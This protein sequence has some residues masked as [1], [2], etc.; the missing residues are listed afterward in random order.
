MN[1][2]IIKSLKHLKLLAQVKTL[3]Y[4]TTDWHSIPKLIFYCLNTEE[5][6]DQLPEEAFFA[7]FEWQCN[8]EG[9]ITLPNFDPIQRKKP[10]CGQ[11]IGLSG[12]SYVWFGNGEALCSVGDTATTFVVHNIAADRPMISESWNPNTNLGP[13]FFCTMSAHLLLAGISGQQDWSYKAGD[14]GPRAGGLKNL[15]DVFNFWSAETYP[16]VMNRFATRGKARIAEKEIREI[17]YKG[18]AKE[19]A[20][21]LPE[22]MAY[23][24]EDVD[25]LVKLF[26]SMYACWLNQLPM[27]ESQY[28][29]FKRAKVNYS[30]DS[31]FKTWFENTEQ[32]Y[33]EALQQIDSKVVDLT[34]SIVTNFT[35]EID[36]VISSNPIEP[37]QECYT[38]GSKYTKLKAK[39]KNA[40]VLHKEYNPKLNFVVEKYADE[41]P[42]ISW[43][44]TNNGLP[45]WADKPITSRSVD[46][47][48]L[49]KPKYRDSVESLVQVKYARECGFYYEKSGLRVKITSPKKGLNTKDNCGS[50]FSKDFIAYWENDTLST[51]APESKEIVQ[52]MG[53]ISYWTSVRSRLAEVYASVI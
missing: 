21:R 48:L 13:N 37:Q 12:K 3:P 29:Y 5:I 22:L 42:C 30:L 28:F 51:E 31:D 23:G 14:L 7:D 35:N 34:Q 9:S 40:Y 1:P 52:L 39:Y 24:L 2:S 26:P 36:E 46:M 38:K 33:Q 53:S 18:T 15:I 20:A 49:L 41:Y 32:K 25:K 44:L 4:E 10:F 11:F 16:E 45:L 17:F 6:T 27:L 50:L 8:H 19:I 43:E 47:Q